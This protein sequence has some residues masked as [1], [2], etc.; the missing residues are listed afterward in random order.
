MGS[1]W[2]DGNGAQLA[3]DLRTQAEDLCPIH[4]HVTRVIAALHVPVD[5]FTDLGELGEGHERRDSRVP[6]LCR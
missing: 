5:R 1:S 6:V 4:D 2:E 3:N